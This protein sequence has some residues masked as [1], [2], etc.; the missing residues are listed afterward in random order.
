[1]RDS[2]EISLTATAWAE[3]SRHAADAFPEECCGVI[4]DCGAGREEVRRFKNIQNQLHALD[5]ETYP[6]EATIAYAMDPKELERT[7]DEAAA[8]GAKLKAFYHS[9]PNHEA[10]FSAE[11]KAFAMPFGE[12]TFPETAQIVISI[13]DRVVKRIRAYGWVE[14]KNDFVEIPLRK[15]SA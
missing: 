3:I 9:H 10:Y 11:D 1:M 7:I 2:V 5:P 14:T 6:R 4:L 13:Y 12:P 15:L 8:A